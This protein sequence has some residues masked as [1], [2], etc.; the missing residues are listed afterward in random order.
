MYNCNICSKSYKWL[1]SLK[2]HIRQAHNTLESDTSDMEDIEASDEMDTDEN[3]CF[4]CGSIYKS[5]K[6]MLKHM[7][8]CETKDSDSDISDISDISS[9]SSEGTEDESAW[10]DLV[11]EVHNVHAEK[12]SQKVEHHE[13]LGEEDP[14]QAAADDM[15]PVYRRTLKK[16]LK[17]RLVFALQIKKSE[18]YK[19]LMKDIHFYLEEKQLELSKAVTSAIRRNVDI[20]N[21]VLEDDDAATDDDGETGEETD[22][23]ESDMNDVNS[24]NDWE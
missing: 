18:H 3:A 20:L 16:L 6:A 5:K 15:L 23:N 17:M 13:S 7:E 1:D 14:R 19:K 2:R 8:T 24:D 22:T 21:E 12:F 4:K 9:A 11:A 10:I